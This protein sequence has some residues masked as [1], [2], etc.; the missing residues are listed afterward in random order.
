V[1]ARLRVDLNAVTKNK[2]HGLTKG[3]KDA[4]NKLAIVKE[5]THNDPF[6]TGRSQPRSGAD[7]HGNGRMVSGGGTPREAL[8]YTAAAGSGGAVVAIEDSDEST[9]ERPKARDE[10]GT[11]PQEVSMGQ[12]SGSWV[13][14]V[15]LEG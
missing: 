9:K 4:P 7:S 12:A 2:V 8:L 14:V 1:T 6:G 11:T 13:G 15:P 3:Y 5:D 10:G